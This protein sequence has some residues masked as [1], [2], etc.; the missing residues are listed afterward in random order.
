VYRF[1]LIT[2]AALPAAAATLSGTVIDAVTRQPV[3]YAQI[4]AEGAPP[5]LA[6]SL[7]RF[8][9]STRS[10]PLRVGAGRIGYNPSSTTV[11]QGSNDVQ[12]W[13][14][15]RAIPQ[16]GITVSAFRTPLPSGQSGPVTALAGTALRRAK[17]ASIADGL[18]GAPGA[19]VRDYGNLSTISVRGANAE[20]TLVLLDGVRLNSAQDNLIDVSALSPVLADRVELARSGASALWGANAS[21]GVLALVTLEPETLGIR[22]E[23]GVGSFGERRARLHHTNA[24]GSLGYG[25]GIDCDQSPNRFTWRDSLDSA[26]TR[27]NAGNAGSSAT[28]KL[29]FREGRHSASILGEYATRRRGSPG[30]VS[31]PSDSARLTDTRGIA[32]LRYAWQQTGGAR[33]EATAFRHAVWRNYHDPD[34]AFG[35]NDTHQTA[36]SGFT[37]TQTI[38]LASPVTLLAAVDADREDLSSTSTG[39]ARRDNLGVA[40]QAR[41]EFGCLAVT[42]NF[43]VDITD[44]TGRRDSAPFRSTRVVPSPRLWLSWSP[45]QHATLYFGA[46]RAFRAP[47]FN[48]L[49]WPEG[50]WTGGN[51]RLAPEWTTNIDAGIRA[52]WRYHLRGGVGLFHNR[53]TDLIQWQ[54]DSASVFRPV[55]LDSATVTGAEVELTSEFKYGGV[56]AQVTWL[57]PRSGGRDLAY[58]PRLAA[59]VQHWL[60]W[61]WI[62]LEWDVRSVGIRY[63]DAANT[64]TLPAWL[65]L[66]LGIDLSPRLGRVQPSIA[67]GIRN[68]FDRRYEMIRDYPLPGRNWYMGL[69]VG[70]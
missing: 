33:L 55:N 44:E 37:A 48:E 49:Y 27:R 38:Q 22:A 18:A 41:G 16:R 5:V 64:D 60:Q 50:R 17:G 26:R 61:R 66:D 4:T 53:H 9:I 25:V 24:V 20:Q 56:T 35:S 19:D 42:P 15:P 62:R 47:T 43:R 31:Y 46:G 13:L 6:D 34:P 59:S 52:T 23:A 8:S 57:A 69:S 2:L 21:G 63:A 14:W 12:V 68:L 39:A 45:T 67:A 30:P 28:A 36:R 29:N 58:R 54:P 51:P 65:T 11:P 7:G 32:Q 40:L 1:L 3:P 10:A 70:L